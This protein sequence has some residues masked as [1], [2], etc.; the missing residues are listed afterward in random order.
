MIF[1]LLVCKVSQS[2]AA[3]NKGCAGAIKDLS[4][5]CTKWPGTR[6]MKNTLTWKGPGATCHS[7]QR[8]PPAV[9]CFLPEPPNGHMQR[10]P[11]DW[12]KNPMQ[13]AGFTGR[14]RKSPQ[15]LHVAMGSW[16]FNELQLE[17]SNS[18]GAE[19]WHG[20]YEYH[21]HQLLN[22][23]SAKLHVCMNDVAAAMV[24]DNLNAA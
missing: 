20:F 2:A 1:V 21:E 7:K 4:V 9:W 12:R 19:H 6:N 10:Q 14:S 15:A 5:S 3:C 18:F 17:R 16:N 22:S 24:H 13:K 11:Q 23:Q 8:F